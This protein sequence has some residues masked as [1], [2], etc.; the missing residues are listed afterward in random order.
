VI[1]SVSEL[2]AHPAAAI[3]AATAQT[4]RSALH[5]ARATEQ[6]PFREAGRE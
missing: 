4:L 1:V 2:E 3:T 6:Y 5:M